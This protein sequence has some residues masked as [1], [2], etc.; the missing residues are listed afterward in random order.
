M[1]ANHQTNREIFKYYLGVGLYLEFYAESTGDRAHNRGT[2]GRQNTICYGI[3]LFEILG[4]DM[5]TSSVSSFGSDS[6]DSREILVI[7][8][9]KYHSILLYLDAHFVLRVDR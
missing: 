4:K 1:S 5:L 6:K 8:A 3:D 7:L 2:L 9:K